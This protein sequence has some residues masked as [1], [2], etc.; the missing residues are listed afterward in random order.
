MQYLRTASKKTEWS[1]FISKANHSISH[2]VYVPITGAEEA[3]VGWSYEDLE[4]L[5]ELTLK[6][7][8]F[9]MG[10]WKAKGGT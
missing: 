7:V 10:N 5:L 2:Q 9:T 6:Y 1:Q 4:H 3:E 8:L